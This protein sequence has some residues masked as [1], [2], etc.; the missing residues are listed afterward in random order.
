M[1][2][3]GPDNALFDC[4]LLIPLLLSPT[5]YTTIEYLFIGEQGSSDYLYLTYMGGFEGGEFVTLNSN[6]L[7]TS[8]AFP[9]KSSAVTD[10]WFTE[11]V[12]QK[13]R[14][15]KENQRIACITVMSLMYVC[16]S[17]T[18]DVD[19]PFDGHFEGE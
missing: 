15:E 18:Q 12:S 4:L 1:F 13:E 17:R 9:K 16:M 11:Q 6:V 14:M 10:V 3:F 2:L 19:D 7:A 5:I 8:G